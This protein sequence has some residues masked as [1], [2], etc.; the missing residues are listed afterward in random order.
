M[1]TTTTTV[2]ESQIEHL[3]RAH[4]AAIQRAA[5]A[6]VERACRQVPMAAPKP[7]A[8]SN[9][10]AERK[11]SGPRR[12]P[13]ELSVLAERL[14]E[15]ICTHPGAPMSELA[16][17]MGLTPRELNQPAKQL[18]LAGRMSSVGQ[19]SATRYYPRNPKTAATP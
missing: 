9:P 10:P 8:T 16:A 7:R 2:L 6:A 5:A 4:V 12:A 18:R 17:Q 1:H 11:S 15:A 13:T 19:R 14:Y 3:V